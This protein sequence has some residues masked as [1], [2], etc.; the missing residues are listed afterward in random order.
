M[1]KNSQIIPISSL[2]FEKYEIDLKQ[3]ILFIVKFKNSS[4]IVG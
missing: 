2:L 3:F 1:R 4:A